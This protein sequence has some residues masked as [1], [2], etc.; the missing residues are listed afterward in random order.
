M[1]I[2]LFLDFSTVVLKVPR[3]NFITLEN[4]DFRLCVRKPKFES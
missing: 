4:R 3:E 1:L 2:E